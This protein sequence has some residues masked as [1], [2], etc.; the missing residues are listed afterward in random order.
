LL[1]ALLI[2][3]VV[4]RLVARHPPLAVARIRLADQFAVGT[5]TQMAGIAVD[6]ALVAFMLHT[7]S[8]G[9]SFFANAGN[10]VVIGVAAACINESIQM[11]GSFVS[12]D[13]ALRLG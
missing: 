13:A 6:R 3:V 5:A 11:C 9:R 12:K 7:K 2:I 8:R 4:V 1:G 10:C